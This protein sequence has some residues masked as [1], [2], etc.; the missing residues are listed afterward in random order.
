MSEEIYHNQD[1][2][3]EN[4]VMP[5]HQ[6]AVYDRFE[7][8]DWLV[9]GTLL[10]SPL[11]H[12]DT[13]EVLRRNPAIAQSELTEVYLPLTGV[14]QL[15]YEAHRSRSGAVG[16]LLRRD[17]R[18]STFILGIA[19]SVAAGKTTTAEI[20]R[21]LLE[22]LPSRPTV[23]LVSTDGFLY[24]G[25]ELTRRGIMSRKGF[26]ESYDSEK[27]I[28]FV[29]RIKAGEK[30]VR[31]PIYSH[32]TYDTV[33]GP[34]VPVGSP[35]ILIIEGIN[36][37]ECLRA[38]AGASELMDF[39]DFSIYLDAPEPLLRKWFLDR[40]LHLREDAKNTPDAYFHRFADMHVEKCLE[41]ETGIWESIDLKNL[42]E[43]ILPSRE[44]ADLILTKGQDH[45]LVRVMIRN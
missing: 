22:K 12:D 13:E 5:E 40:F 9:L 2:R 34:G 6:A 31:A 26:P 32:E 37:L 15:F 14:L 21:L 16:R 28:D 35:D 20:L 36:V 24:P 27:I 19:G 7:R 43:N 33:E 30:D 4:G 1:K 17:T 11:S 38:D 29:R 45:K 10:C 44:R 8:D 23:S 41:V 25:K 42:M 3:P 18:P 39:T